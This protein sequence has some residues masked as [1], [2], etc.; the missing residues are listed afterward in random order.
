MFIKDGLTYDDLLLVP[1]YSDIDSRSDVDLGVSINGLQFKHPLIPA[2]MQSITGE[3]M[4]EVVIKSG[5]LAIL[6]RFMPFEEQLDIVDRLGSRVLNV[7]D[8]LA[9]SIGI[10]YEDKLNIKRFYDI[11]VR[12]FCIDIA[13]GD[14]KHAIEMTQWIRD[15]YEKA[16]IIAGNV[17]TG[18]GATRLWKAGADVVKVRSWRRV[19]MHNKNRDW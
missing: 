19:F 8:Y 5:G 11:G 17:A 4:A 14:S 6:H 18:S 16:I 13:H 7:M 15:H 12:I 10:K 1:Q 2:N 9:V 3:K